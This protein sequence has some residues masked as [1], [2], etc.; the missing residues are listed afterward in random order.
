MK[1]LRGCLDKRGQ[2]KLSFGMIFSIIL[3][4]AFLAFTVYAVQKFLGIQRSIQIAA[5]GDD[6]QSDIDKMWRGSQGSEI[7][8]YNLPK[9]IKKVCFV[10]FEKSAKGAD[11]LLYGDLKMAYFGYENM[12]FYP[13]GS[14]EGLDAKEIL[15]IDLEKITAADNPLCLDNDGKVK[16]TIS[17]SPGD[18]LV[19][20]T[21]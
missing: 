12:I 13:V 19:T 9:Q 2:M 8:E 18:A 1:R 15:H 3:I 10:D 16:M 6:L 5:F 7:E 11:G 4:L 17:M 21:K 14:G 20:I